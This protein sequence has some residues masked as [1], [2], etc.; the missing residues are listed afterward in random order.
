MR[1]DLRA[2]SVDEVQ[3]FRERVLH[4]REKKHSK[5]E[6]DDA[7]ETLHLGA[8]VGTCLAAVGTICRASM[9]DNDDIF[10]PNSWRLRGMATLD[11]FRSRGLGKSVAKGCVAHAAS[12]GA[13]IV[14]CSARQSAVGFYRSLGFE[15]EGRSFPLPEY[16]EEK[17]TLMKLSLWRR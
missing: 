15:K 16:S 3:A 12:R 6:G 9:F 7:C 11:Q 1:V 8:F 17:Y 4:P 10:H 5:Y 2:I 13:T 14:W